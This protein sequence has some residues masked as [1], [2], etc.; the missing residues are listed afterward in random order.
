MEQTQRAETVTD[1]LRDRTTMTPP[2]PRPCTR[3]QHTEPLCAQATVVRLQMPQI[4][5]LRT[6]R[7]HLRL[8][9]YRRRE[10]K[11]PPAR[12]RPETTVRASRHVDRARS[13]ACC[14]PL[15]TRRE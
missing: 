4:E 12:R 13:G 9:C 5:D 15:S 3:A 2:R 8:R 11:I 1:E 7:S 10:A 14:W 6:R